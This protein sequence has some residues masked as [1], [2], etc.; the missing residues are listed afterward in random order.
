M[1]V[2]TFHN[3]LTYTTRPTINAMVGG[4]LTTKVVDGAWNPIEEMNSTTI[5]G[6]MSHLGL[7]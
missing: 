2:N 3:R 6:P 7:R 5:N 4:I 1:I